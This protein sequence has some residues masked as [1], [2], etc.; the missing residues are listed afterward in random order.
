MNEKLLY[1]V[2]GAVAVLHNGKRYEVGET[3]EL[4][5]E[6]AQ[7]I[8]LYVELTESGKVKLAQQQRN[9]EEAQRKAE[10]AKNNKEATTNTANANTENQA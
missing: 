2:I 3:L 5:Q 6:E 9:A 4:T 7:N 8:A 1:A 10:E